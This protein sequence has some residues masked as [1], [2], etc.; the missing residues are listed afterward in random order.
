MGARLERRPPPMK[1]CLLVHYCKIVSI[2]NSV[3]LSSTDNTA[4]SH[5]AGGYNVLKHFQALSPKPQRCITSNNPI[6]VQVASRWWCRR[7]EGVLSHELFPRQDACHV[8]TS[9]GE[10]RRDVC[11]F[12]VHVKACCLSPASQMGCTA[13]SPQAPVVYISAVSPPPMSRGYTCTG[14]GEQN[15]R[16]VS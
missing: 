8:C 7:Q 15:D 4:S 1:Q 16:N 3:I 9:T 14:Y 12:R 11:D 6:N 13:C 10:C 2:S 5:N